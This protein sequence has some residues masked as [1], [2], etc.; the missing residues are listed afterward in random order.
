MHAG[1]K[2][3]RVRRDT[4]AG[5]LF[6]AP[7]FLGFVLFS[8]LPLVL[9]IVLSFSQW[10]LVTGLKGIQ[11]AGLENYKELIGDPVF[12][13][14]LKNN[15]LFAVW[16]LPALMILG[17]LGAILIDDFTFGKKLFK[18]IYFLPYISSAV[19]VATVWRVVF[20]PS[21]GPINSFL[22]SM[23][24]ENPPKWLADPNWALFTITLMFIW[25]N[26][27]Y[28]ILVYI[29]G[30]QAIPQ[31]I[32]E[33]ADIDGATKWQKVRYLTVPLVSPT[34][35]FLFVTGMISTFKIFDAIQI[36]TQGGPGTS[37][38]V[39]VHYLYKASFEYYKIGYGSAISIVLFLVVVL[40]TIIQWGGQKKW[41]NY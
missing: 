15:I 25:Q 36:L 27:G 4:I 35:F 16:A 12:K 1:F 32:Y 3:K 21:Y 33:A 18:T 8:F 30:L 31:D 9:T 2:N 28:Y 40:I 5:C 20:Q 23:G 34:T 11:F 13:E 19:A 38:S 17:L 26:I 7:S 10:E 29:T 14:S 41:V 6:I 39:L 22:F 37:S 24:M